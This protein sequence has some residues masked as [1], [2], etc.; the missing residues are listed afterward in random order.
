MQG[1]RGRGVHEPDEVVALAL[2]VREAAAAVL[3]G[4]GEHGVRHGAG[5]RRGE[6][7][8]GAG[9]RGW[10]CRAR[11]GCGKAV[12]WADGGRREEGHLQHG[13]GRVVISAA[14]EC[15]QIEEFDDAWRR[16]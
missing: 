9:A 8:R 6:R 16:R 14:W 1:A 13:L 4:V 15:P 5:G 7:E 12:R 2:G 10:E 11:G 3:R